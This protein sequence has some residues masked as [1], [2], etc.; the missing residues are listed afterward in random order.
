MKRFLWMAVLVACQPINTGTKPPRAGLTGPRNE[1]IVQTAPSDSS[2]NPTPAITGNGAAES[3]AGS[4]GGT[5]IVGQGGVASG[6]G[7][8]GVGV[9]GTSGTPVQAGATGVLGEG[10]IGVSGSPIDST[11]NSIGVS[12][13]V[14]ADGQ[15]AVQG[16]VAGF[17]SPAVKG[18]SSGVG[19]A[20][21]GICSGAGVAVQASATGSGTAVLANASF[22]TGHALE[23]APNSTTAAV[24]IDVQATP[25]SPAT[26]EMWTDSTTGGAAWQTSNGKAELMHVTPHALSGVPGGYKNSWADTGAPGRYWTDASGLI[27]LDGQLTKTPVDTTLIVTLPVGFRPSVVKDFLVPVPGSGTSFGAVLTI[28]SSGDVALLDLPGS[29]GNTVNLEQIVFAPN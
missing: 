5:G 20:I 12:G 16:A 9:T 27:H 4:Q 22:G 10:F 25:G 13:T 28:Q 26:G 1:S 24:K 3:H 19:A 6:G 2:G 23:A 17:N 15:V 29:P 21:L 8:G 11:A 14:A 7:G 18:T